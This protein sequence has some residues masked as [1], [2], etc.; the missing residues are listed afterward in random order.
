MDEG[1]CLSVRCDQH[2]VGRG[3]EVE[4]DGKKPCEVGMSVIALDELE[5]ELVEIG[6]QITSAQAMVDADRPDLEAGEDAMDP[7]QN[8]MGCHRADHM[9]FMSSSRAN[10]LRV[11]SRP[12]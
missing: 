12:I 11:S 2:I 8:D 9:G 1:L 10:R 5:H 4:S 7:G 3:F 6:L